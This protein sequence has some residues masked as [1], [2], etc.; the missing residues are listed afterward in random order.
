MN[1]SQP[2]R[3]I[4]TPSPAT[5]QPHHKPSDV[6]DLMI[7]GGVHHVPVLFGTTLIGLLDSTALMRA[8]YSFDGET[9]QTKEA[10]D[11]TRSIEDLMQANPVTIGASEPIRRAAE[12]LADGWFDCLPVVDD[13]E[14]VG[15]IT[16]ADLILY[17]LAQDGPAPSPRSAMG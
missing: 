2:V 14:L 8:L 17:L 13:G 15:M 10:L 12:V 11:Q 5:V 7:K 6:I 16:S 9:R 4:M 3:H 1:R